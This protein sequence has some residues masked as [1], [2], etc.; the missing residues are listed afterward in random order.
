M[1]CAPRREFTP[2]WPRPDAG[3]GL[4][5]L[6]FTPKPDRF[7]S[8]FI[9]KPLHHQTKPLIIQIHT[10]TQLSHSPTRIRQTLIRINQHIKDSS[11]ISCYFNLRILAIFPSEVTKAHGILHKCWGNS[12][13]SQFWY[14]CKIN[15]FSTGWVGFDYI[16]ACWIVRIAIHCEVWK[17]YYIGYPIEFELA[18]LDDLRLVITIFWLWFSLN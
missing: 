2:C 17:I 14:S 12:S 1:P 6:I 5:I 13:F 3:C 10:Q 16:I 18:Q 11:L 15:W 7:C 4:Q 9:S 8:F